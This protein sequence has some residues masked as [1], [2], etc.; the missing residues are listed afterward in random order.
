[1]KELDKTIM[2]RGKAL[3]NK[4]LTPEQISDIAVFMKALSGDIPAD[5]KQI[6]AAF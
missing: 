6:P 2:I 1:M 4:D 3:L 5:A